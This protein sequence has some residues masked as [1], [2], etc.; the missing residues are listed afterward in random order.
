MQALVGTLVD[1][2]AGAALRQVDRLAGKLDEIATE[3][4]VAPNAL[5][6]GVRAVLQGKNPLWGA[7]TSAVAAMS[8]KAKI[9][10]VLVLIVAVLLLPVLLLVLVVALLVTAVVAAVRGTSGHGG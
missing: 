4:G 2:A 9:V 7:V 1:R 3:G 6:G 10:L 5:L 8:P